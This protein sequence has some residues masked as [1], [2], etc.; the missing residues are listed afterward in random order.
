MLLFTHP[1]FL[2]LSPLLIIGCF[3]ISFRHWLQARY[4]QVFVIYLGLAGLS[5][6]TARAAQGLALSPKLALLSGI[7]IPALYGLLYV[8]FEIVRSLRSPYRAVAQPYRPSAW[9]Q[10]VGG[11]VGGC[12]GGIT[13]SSLGALF[14]LM[15][16]LVTPLLTL[17]LGWQLNQTV[18]RW[19]EWST[20]LFG[21]LGLLLGLLVGWGRLNFKQLGDRVLIALT[22]QSF[23]LTTAVKRLLKLNPRSGQQPKD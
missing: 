11:T 13:G 10:W 20:A 22:I 17:D 23:L 5:I 21:L 4:S 3:L 9:R 19:M 2:H 14:G 6:L 1:V 8:G 12:V 15:L 7:C 18:Q 16:F